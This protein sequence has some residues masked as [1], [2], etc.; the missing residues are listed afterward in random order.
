MENLLFSVISGR[1]VGHSE[2]GRVRVT[3]DPV[4]PTEELFDEAR[5]A[6]TYTGSGRLL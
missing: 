6:Y 2:E 1:A 5:Y 4:H 3:G